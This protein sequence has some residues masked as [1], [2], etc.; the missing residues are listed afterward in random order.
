MLRRYKVVPHL[1]PL[2]TTVPPFCNR[3]CRRCVEE[4]FL[5]SGKAVAYW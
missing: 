5:T 2:A 3:A 1:V 4:G